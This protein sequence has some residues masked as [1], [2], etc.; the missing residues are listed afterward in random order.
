MAY[1][2]PFHVFDSNEDV[3][4]VERKLPHWAQSGTI[5]FITFRT[6]DSMPKS[7]LQRWLNE[8][9]HWLRDHDIDPTAEDWKAKLQESGVETRQEFHRRFS[10][11]WHEELD[12]CHGHVYCEMRNSPKS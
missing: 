4:I 8:R 9:F 3:L 6:W 5:S 2:F 11:R 10:Q 1:D 12:Q 7:V